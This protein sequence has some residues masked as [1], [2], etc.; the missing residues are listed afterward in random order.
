MTMATLIAT[1]TFAAGFT[2]PGG[3]IQD[4]S[5]DQGMAVLSLPT[6]GTKGTD[7]DMANAVR[8]D[9]KK[10]VVA[11]SVAMVLSLFAI[12]INFL[13]TFPVNGKKAIMTF[14]SYGY[15]LTTGAMMAMVIAFVEGLQAVLRHSELLKATTSFIFPVFFIF[16][17]FHIYL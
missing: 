5:N 17:W 16:F 3:Y 11:D 2:L 6:N 7:G 14:V 12:G 1:V 4:K 15:M 8:A 9:F 10:F 13:A